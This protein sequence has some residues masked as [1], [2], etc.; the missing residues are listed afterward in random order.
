MSK[1]SKDK[2]PS[3]ATKTE[4]IVGGTAPTATEDAKNVTMESVESARAALVERIEAKVREIEQISLAA[5]Q[6]QKEAGGKVRQY[7]SLIVAGESDLAQRALGEIKASRT[8]AAAQRDRLRD[9][10]GQ[11]DDLQ[12]EVN[13]LR[14]QAHAVYLSEEALLKAETTV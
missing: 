6:A 4:T 3:A 1:T 12:I 8:E 11:A 5:D 10:V 13:A 14:A 7:D 9:I 2:T